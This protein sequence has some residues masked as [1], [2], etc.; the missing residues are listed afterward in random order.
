MSYITLAQSLHDTL[1]QVSTPTEAS[2]KIAQEITTYV[3]RD[4]TICGMRSGV[5]P[6]GTVDTGPV[7]FKLTGAVNPETIS[8]ID[9][10]NEET[11]LTQ[12][13]TRIQKGIQ[14]AFTIIPSDITIPTIIPTPTAFPDTKWLSTTTT[15]PALLTIDTM[16]NKYLSYI[17]SNNQIKN[18]TNPRLE[19][20]KLLAKAI[21][22]GIKAA[23]ISGLTMPYVNLTFKG[24]ITLTNTKVI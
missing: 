12:W 1:Y 7:E 13:L 8:S 2:I 23:V 18:D 10:S 19:L 4:I 6:K 22:D 14:E 24:I 20:M 21:E 5:D 15:I 17:D 3:I 9:L 11:A 16:K